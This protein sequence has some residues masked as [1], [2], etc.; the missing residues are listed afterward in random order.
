MSRRRSVGNFLKHPPDSADAVRDNGAIMSRLALS[1]GAL[2]AR[3][4]VV[5]LA[6]EAPR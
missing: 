2:R 1:R 3:R 6:S 4:L 5:V